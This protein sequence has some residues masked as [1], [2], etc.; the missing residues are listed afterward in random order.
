MDE[1]YVEFPCL[2]INQP[3]GVFYV[4]VIDA[5]DLVEISYADVRRMEER[6]VEQYLGIQRPLVDSRVS[7]IKQYVRTVDAAFPTSVIVAISSDDAQYDDMVMRVRRARSV[8]KIIDGQHRIAGL[9]GL[10]GAVFQLN[11]AIFVDMELE[12]QAMMFATINLKQTRVSKSLAY[13][14][15]E[16]ASSR[17]PQKTAHNI[18]KLLNSKAG[19]PLHGKIKMLGRATGK[20]TETITQAA[21]VDRL[22]PLITDAPMQDRDAIKRGKQLERATEDERRR[23]FRNLFIDG[24]DATIAANFWNFFEAISERWPRAWN[25]RRTGHVLNRTTGLAALMRFL[26][27]LYLASDKSEPLPKKY[28]ANCVEGIDLGDDDFTTE[29]FKPGSSGESA[30]LEVFMKESRCTDT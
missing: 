30:L 12:D 13:D 14:L 27:E 21:F 26:R 22:L 29:E 1:P 5:A 23:I 25:E 20:S 3:I 16:Y 7:E 24:R 19:S 8:A 9:E 28:F 17:S 11:V 4:G 10:H 15:H 6:D 18:A 2:E